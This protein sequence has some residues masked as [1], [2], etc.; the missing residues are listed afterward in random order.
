MAL[1]ATHIRFALD[2]KDKYQVK[3]LKKYI[4]G[5]IY[6]DSRY[7]TGVGRLLTHP[8]DYFDWHWEIADDFKK[9]WLIHLLADKIQYRV[10]KEILPDVFNGATGQGSEVWI[11]HSAI[12]NLLDLDDIKK[13]DIKHYLPYLA[14]AENPNGEDIEK[15]REYNQI[16][17]K[18]YS[19]LL[20]VNINSYCEMWK[21]IGIG[22]E[23]ALKIK[24]QTENYSKNNEIMEAVGK[25][26]QK[27][28]NYK[29][30]G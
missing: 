13:F 28:L 2:L 5:T 29:L 8:T 15:I 14:Y 4:I 21:K 17:A 27:M 26:Y 16:F 11:K 1:E 23:L 10:T 20:K 24:A 30:E 18:M 7:V 12:K 22:D 25:I 9:G 6:P 19:D 3:N